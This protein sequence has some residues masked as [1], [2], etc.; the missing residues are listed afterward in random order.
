MDYLAIFLRRQV[1]LFF[2]V[3]GIEPDSSVEY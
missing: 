3:A 1:F 2:V